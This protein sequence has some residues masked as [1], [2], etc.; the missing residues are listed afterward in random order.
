MSKIDGVSNIV[1]ISFTISY[2]LI[3]NRD[4]SYKRNHH[5]NEYYLGY[6]DALIDLLKE[7]DMP[8]EGR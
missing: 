3:E 8:Y 7:L 6:H 1:L 2:L 5:N 4:N